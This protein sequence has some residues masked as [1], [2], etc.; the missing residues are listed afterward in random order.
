MK[1][2]FLAFTCALA[3]SL[4][5]VNTSSAVEHDPGVIAADAL[6]ARP[7]GFVA[8]IVGGVTFVLALPVAAT[9]GSID[10]A[11]DSL[12]AQPAWWTFRRPLG[13]FDYTGEY[14]T[15]FPGK[16]ERAVA[17]VHKDVKRS[18]LAKRNRS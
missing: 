16:Q 3:L 2:A 7:L 13:D 9:S 5:F 8:T 17:M 11:A 4:T 18:K 6:L 15:R 14:G 10:S 1:T 12:V